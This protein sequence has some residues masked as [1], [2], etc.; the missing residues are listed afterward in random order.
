MKKIVVLLVIFTFFFIIRRFMP[1]ADVKAAEV[2]FWNFQ[3]IDTMKYSRDVAREKLNDTAYKREIAVQV[4]NIAQ[5][6]ATHVGVA[7]P[8]DD[9]FYPF[10]K[11]WVDEARSNN[12]HVWFRGNWSGWEGWFGYPRISREEHIKKT[13]EYIRS[14]PELFEDGDVFSAC[15]ECEN[16]GPG[17]PRSN[18]DVAGHRTF[19]I[20]EYAVTKQAFE[21]IG[22]SVISNFASMNADVARLIMDPQTTTAMDHIVVIDHYVATAEQLAAD[23]HDI[24]K[25]SGGMVVLGEFGAPVPDINGVMSEDEQVAWVAKA[26]L[27]LS[28]EPSLVGVSYW[29]NKGGSTKLWEED[30]S[31]RKVVDVL[32]QAYKPRQLTALVQ[33]ELGGSVPEGT[34]VRPDGIEVPI[35]NGQ[36]VLPY[37]DPNDRIT[38]RAKGYESVE[39]RA[40]DVPSVIP[41][42]VTNPTFIHRILRF[43]HLSFKF[44]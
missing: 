29:V 16:G 34:A 10:L 1:L 13:G 43:L 19:L 33:T 21:D 35:T 11:Q 24:A 15:P 42:R 8:Y 4:Q 26:L 27:L 22:V 20:D 38:V 6:G 36:L 17:D 32:S 9:E 39:F 44:S 7:T 37:I 28:R 3:A 18:G 23:I 12:L 40:G 2:Q 25:Q 30:N 41:L 5:T 31:P 14:H